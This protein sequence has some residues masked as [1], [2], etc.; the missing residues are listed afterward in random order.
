MP[1]QT[2]SRREGRAAEAAGMTSKDLLGSFL[3]GATTQQDYSNTEGHRP[4]DLSRD[5]PARPIRGQ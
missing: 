3:Q 2:A 5:I 4:G 1:E